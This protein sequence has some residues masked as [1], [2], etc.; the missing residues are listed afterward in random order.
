M[1]KQGIAI[2]IEG[3]S[4]TVDPMGDTIAALG[5]RVA[6]PIRV[7]G[8]L[9]LRLQGAALRWADGDDIVEAL[10]DDRVERGFVGADDATCQRKASA[11]T[12][13]AA[14]DEGAVL[15]VRIRVH[16]LS[17]TARLSGE[18]T[19]PL[20]Y[21]VGDDLWRRISRAIASDKWG[22]GILGMSFAKALAEP[23]I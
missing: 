3:G 5:G 6:G 19:P 2:A 14:D 21:A 7:L 18:A 16:V 13:S 1:S 10:R 4:I 23:L 20:L 9:A 22:M 17:V 15:T 8:L 12:I 11:V